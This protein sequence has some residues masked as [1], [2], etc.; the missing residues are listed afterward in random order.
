VGVLL[1]TFEIFDLREALYQRTPLEVTTYLYFLNFFA[2][3]NKA[4]VDGD[5]NEVKAALVQFMTL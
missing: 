2:V 1:S 4:I 5:V 3:F